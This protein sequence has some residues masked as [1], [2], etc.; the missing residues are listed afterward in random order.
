MD[1]YK[2]EELKRMGFENEPGGL[3]L[4]KSRAE[5]AALVWPRKAKLES[6]SNFSVYLHYAEVP[7]R[8]KNYIS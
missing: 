4:Y 2:W 7:R 1:E 3:L 6:E 5:R 8:G